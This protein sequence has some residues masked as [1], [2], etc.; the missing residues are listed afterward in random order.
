MIVEMRPARIAPARKRAG[1]R[2]RSDRNMARLALGADR[3][4][5]GVL[6]RCGL[7]ADPPNGHDRGRVLELPPQLADMD[8]DG[9]G[10]TRERI[11]PDALEQLVPGEHEA[12]VIE[13]LPEQV[14]LLWREL[15]VLPV[16]L[17]LTPARVDQQGAVP[18]LR[19]LRLAA[20]RGR[21]AQDRLDPRN[22]LPRV[23]RLREVVVRADLEADD[24]VDVFVT[25]RQHQDRDVRLLP[26]A[27]ADL[28]TIAVRKH[29]VEDDQ[30]RRRRLRLRE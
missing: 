22:E 6:G 23:E 16:D 21:A 27:A 8:V 20:L 12:V 7:V 28:D 15:D 1:K 26:D 13:Q 9:A 19:R 30:R 5:R 2:K 25:R 3:V 11:A 4:L 10:V 17:H 18:D 24:L 29:E 14:E